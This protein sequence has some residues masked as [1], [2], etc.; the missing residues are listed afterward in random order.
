MPAIVA[1]GGPL[2]LS[3]FFSF[4]HIDTGPV[5]NLSETAHLIRLWPYRPSSAIYALLSESDVFWGTAQ[6]GLVSSWI[7]SDRGP[8]GMNK[9]DER[10]H[11][12][13]APGHFRGSSTLPP[14]F[15]FAEPVPLSVS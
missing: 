1:L 14:A 11:L 7:R 5:K 9:R 6:R 13:Q 3:S 8:H 12:H 2:A 4:S 10:L 15:M